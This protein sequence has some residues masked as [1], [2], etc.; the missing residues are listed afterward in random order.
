[1][2]MNFLKEYPRTK[3]LLASLFIG[4]VLGLPMVL[5]ANIAVYLILG[6]AV[7]AVAFVF[8]LCVH[9]DREMKKLYQRKEFV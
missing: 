3:V 1:M 7:S 9:E 5:S 8:W 6:F 4:A 2:N